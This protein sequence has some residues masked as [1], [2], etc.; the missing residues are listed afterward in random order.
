MITIQT[1]LIQKEISLDSIHHKIR[2]FN[3]Y[4][5]YPFKHISYFSEIKNRNYATWGILEEDLKN[6]PEEF[7]NKGLQGFKV[8]K[9]CGK[10][11]GYYDCKDKSIHCKNCKNLT[12]Y[13]GCG[14]GEEIKYNGN[15]I[16]G[17]KTKGKT[18]KEI[19]GENRP[20]CGFKSGEDNVSK[21]PE[22]REKISK[23][24]LKSYIDDPNLRFTKF[25]K[26]G[27]RKVCYSKVSQTLFW[28]IYYLLKEEERDNIYF[29]ELNKEFQKTDNI[30]HKGWYYDFTDTFH[31][32]IIEFNG[33]LFHANPL[34]YKEN[35]CPSPFNKN[36]TAKEI[37]E[38]DRIKIDFVK[39]LGFD[40]LIIWHSDYILN[41]N[42][43]LKKCINFLKGENNENN[44][45]IQIRNSAYSKKC[46]F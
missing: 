40:V 22:I 42:R 17:H 13:C 24:V 9:T 41:P 5:G 15:Y 26:Q 8:C 28:N 45:T 3:E 11:Y 38:Y 27:Q 7:F 18:Y 43:E 36:L 37:W 6:L 39:L 34:I 20:R 23:G 19:Y 31:R 21:K 30:K 4:F 1:L 35:D 2:R 29:G 33:D 16:R 44:Q 32:K 10:L 25:N 14:C 12:Y 46:L